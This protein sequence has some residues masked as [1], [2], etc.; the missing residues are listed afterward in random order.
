MIVLFCATFDAKDRMDV[1]VEISMCIRRNVATT[2]QCQW[3]FERKKG[4][5]CS[6]ERERFAGLQEMVPFRAGQQAGPGAAA[7]L[8]NLNFSNAV[9]YGAVL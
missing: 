3:L 2:K 4:A 1:N 9:L 7:D 6:G 8:K 5:R